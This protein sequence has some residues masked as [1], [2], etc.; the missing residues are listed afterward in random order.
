ML[1]GAKPG[2]EAL[3]GVEDAIVEAAREAPVVLSIDDIQWGDAHT[4]GLLQMLIER[5]SLANSARLF[6]VATAR[7]EPHPSAPLQSLLGHVRSKA[8][9]GVKHLALGPLTAEDTA[10]LGRA[11]CPIDNAVER[12]LVRGSG[13]V[14]FFVVHALQAWRETDAI[15]WRDGAWRAVD[16]RLSQED[17]P[18]VASLV[19]ARIASYF[20]PSS[21]EWR[22]AFRAFAAIALYG[23]GIPVDM[24][25]R[26]V[27][28][29]EIS[30]ER[31][32][33]VLV[34]AGIITVTG[35]RQ[36]YGFAQ[37]MVRQAVLNLVRS[38]PWFHRLH[39][40]LLDTIAEE[41]STAD[42][43]FLASG[44]EKLGLRQQA[45]SWLERAMALAIRTGLFI[46][47]AELGDRLAGLADGPE[48]RVDVALDVVRALILGRTFEGVKE[49]LVRIE[50]LERAFPALGPRARVQQVKR[51]IYQLEAARWLHES[52]E[53]PTL[54]TDADE[55]R[56]PVLSCKARLAIAGVSRG[57]LAIVLATEAITLAERLDPAIEFVARILRVDLN[58]AAS[59][60]DPELE[61][62]DLR[63]A[64]TIATATSSQWQQILVEGDLAVREA[65]LGR[66]ADAIERFQR[67]VT[68]AQTL[69]MREQH[70]LLSHNLS[71]CLMR[72]NRAVEAAASA[73]RTADLA[74]EAGDPMLRGVALSLRAHALCVTGN[75][76]A[77]LSCA[78]EAELLQRERNDRMRAQT[79]LR[80][81]EILHALGKIDAAYDD[82]RAAR[83]AA[84][85]HGENGFVVTAALWEA[86]HLAQQGRVTKDDLVL[87][88]ADVEQA[89][90]GQ[91]AL[92]RSLMERSAAWLGWRPQAT[93]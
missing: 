28:G 50:A 73:Q 82:A 13:G 44:Y 59:P 22:A 18:G 15:T 27:G 37:E 21:A 32:L 38:R 29:D 31:A 43:A 33:E 51:R 78:V 30:I 71:T 87:A 5:V 72:A 62:R 65:E 77:A 19:E 47:A 49:R 63:R 23:G 61:E 67:L 74:A 48:E 86:L 46:D 1:P 66:V 7:D 9:R 57:E 81:A 58:Y 69:G 90:V 34:D 16:S 55:L 40:T 45:R 83:N 54:I 11:V 56:E 8:R 52:G 36:E 89:G 4:L 24:V 10:A 92:A 85:E 88:M 53:D 2:N 76:E 17:V 39:R 35:D 20:E 84:A 26:I 70:R 25:F 60:R 41:P 3:E 42:A 12:A 91:R 79:L 75:L 64:L 80:R 14:P 68:Q 93:P 6:V